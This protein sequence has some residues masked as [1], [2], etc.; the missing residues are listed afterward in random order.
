MYIDFSNFNNKNG[1]IK[2]VIIDSR[3]STPFVYSFLF[4]GTI[5]TYPNISVCNA[6]PPTTNTT[7]CFE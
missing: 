1:L 6:H 4:N 2:T 3:I 7:N 5:I